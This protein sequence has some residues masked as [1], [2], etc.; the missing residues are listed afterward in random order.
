M[1]IIVFI[2]YLFIYYYHHRCC[3]C[4]YCH[5]CSC[6]SPVRG[7]Q[8]ITFS[9]H[10]KSFLW[11]IIYIK[12]PDYFL[13]VI[14]VTLQ[15]PTSIPIRPLPTTHPPTKCQVSRR[16]S[17]QN[18]P[19]FWPLNLF[20]FAGAGSYYWFFFV[21]HKRSNKEKDNPPTLFSS[22]IGQCWEECKWEKRKERCCYYYYYYHCIIIL[23][24]LLH[25]FC[26]I[27]FWLLLHR[28]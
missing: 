10:S 25:K 7:R 22:L 2:I 27:R 28:I 18:W 1:I 16:L 26:F 12:V 15:S 14:L 19:F 17:L 13:P 21:Y 24:L 9:V 23:L 4:W 5:C 11:W 6:L 8:A 3:H 20:T